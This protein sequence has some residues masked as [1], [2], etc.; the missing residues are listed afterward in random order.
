MDKTRAY[1]FDGNVRRFN[2]FRVPGPAFTLNFRSHDLLQ[3][4]SDF[5]LKLFPQRA[6][7]INAGYGRSLAKG[8]YNPSYSFERD[9]FQLLGESRWEAND[10]CLGLD[11]T[12][13][14]WDFIV[15]Q[16]YRNFRNDSS[17]NSRPGVDPGA[18][19]GTPAG[20]HSRWT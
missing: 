14:R 15:E 7:R 19:L 10:Y 9:L 12:Y 11:A 6:V 4:I 1:R 2:Y 16:L 18:N 5:N 13:R 17:I 20:T 8:R 3:Q